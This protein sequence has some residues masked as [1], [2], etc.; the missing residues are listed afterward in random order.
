MD[1][2]TCI[3][4]RLSLLGQ[5][6]W[7]QDL[8]TLLDII[9]TATYINALWVLPAAYYYCS[10]E[11]ASHTLRDTSS[12]NNSQSA[13]VLRNVLAGKINLEIMDVA[14]HD[15]L[16]IPPCSECLHREN[17]ALYK[18]VTGQ[19]YRQLITQRKS[20]GSGA[21]TLKLWWDRMWLKETHCKGMCAPCSS[22]CMSA[23]ESVR[24]DYWDKIPSAFNLP[25]WEELKSLRETNFGEW[26]QSTTGGNPLWTFF[27]SVNWWY[28]S[29]QWTTFPSCSVLSFLFAFYLL[30]SHYDPQPLAAVLRF[31]A[32]EKDVEL[33]FLLL[34][35]KRNKSPVR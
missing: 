35:S 26:K 16:G 2:D 32:Y 21:H 9:V 24:G 22:A 14:Y 28:F 27:G 30:E 17:C 31:N 10:N 29:V 3:P 19:G 7:F 8:K 12:W 23:Y 25:S 11:R 20:A 15:L 5:S 4:R 18:L 13:I 1:M 33:F 34:F 6:S